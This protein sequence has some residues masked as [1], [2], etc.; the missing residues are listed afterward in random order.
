M[1]KIKTIF[2]DDL[3]FFIFLFLLSTTLS[4]YLGRLSIEYKKNDVKETISF[5]EKKE[6]KQKTLEVVASKNGK[7]YSYPWC[8]G[9]KR[10]SEKNKV[11][12]KSKKEAE[13]AGYREAKNCSGF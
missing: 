8:S 3:Y 13:N 4:F 5:L 9:A 6:K 7:T 12:F 10:I 1:K 2:K 11:I